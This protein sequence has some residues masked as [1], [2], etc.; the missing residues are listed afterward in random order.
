M[1][2]I[3][4]MD[5]V[6]CKEIYVILNKLGLFYKLPAELKEYISKN[7]DLSHS[8]SFNKDMPL[9]YQIDN[10]KTKAYL[11]Y[12]YLKYIND[13]VEE[14]NILLNKYQENEQIYQEEQREKYNPDN[15]FK[16]R[17][18]ETVEET[19]EPVAIAV[20]NESIFK[21][22]INKIKNIFSRKQ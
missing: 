7:Q 5:S 17:K 15:M 6:I 14:K 10:E 20:K 1:E 11:S 4:T 12:L 13:S 16:N 19:Q 3:R 9:I 21:R 22:I 18:K 2:E 8:Y